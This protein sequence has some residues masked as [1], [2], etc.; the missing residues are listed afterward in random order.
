MWLGPLGAVHRIRPQS[1]GGG[2]L[3]WT[4]G[5]RISFFRCGRPNFFGAKNFGFFEIMVCPHEQGG[6]VEPIRTFCGQ[7]E[8]DF[9]WAPFME[10][11]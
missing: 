11:P 2:C 8:E 9:V 10:G 3:V 6:G 7:G 5:E 1:G 4:R